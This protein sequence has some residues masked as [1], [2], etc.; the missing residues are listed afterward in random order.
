MVQSNQLTTDIPNHSLNSIVTGQQDDCDYQDDRE[1]DLYQVD[2]TTDVQTPNDDLDDNEDNEPDNTAGKRQKKTYATA[3]TIRK[4]MTKQRCADV[5]KKQQ[6][7]EKA[8]TQA[9]KHKDKID[10]INRPK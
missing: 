5:L 4:E 8:K 1:E 3:N 2:G 9:E 6:E 7:K 10:N